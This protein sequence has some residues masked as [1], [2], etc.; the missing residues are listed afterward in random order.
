MKPTSVIFLIVSILLA[1]LGVLLCVTATSLATEQGVGI[2][3]QVGDED[4]NY[5]AT[6]YFSEEELKKIVVKV[7]NVSVNVIGGAEESKIELVN[8][9][10]GAYSVQAGRSTLQISDNAGISGIIDLE[11]FKI[12]FNGFRDYLPYIRNFVLGLPQKEQVLNVYLTDDADLVNFNINVGSGDITVSGLNVDCDYKIVLESGVVHFEDVITTS[13]VQIESI[14]SSNIDIKKVETNELRIVSPESEC[15]I[16]ISETT[17]T[18]AMYV[19]AKSGDIVYDR[20]ENDF[21]GLDVILEALGNTVSVWGDNYPDTYSE[22]NA[23][24]DGEEQPTDPEGDETTAPEDE[25]TA[26]EDTA[27]PADP[28]ETGDDTTS[29]DT[30]EIG[31]IEDDEEENSSVTVKANTI[32]IKIGDGKIEVK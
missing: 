17:F 32:T 31:D 25:T 22:F 16:N 15:F 18:R 8:F 2:F 5:V 24:T 26:P 28:D 6:E 19:E 10:N 27:V 3:A 13:S 4:D 14:Q 30:D 9:A 20:V 7:S 1:C 12:N 23:P 21:A 11:N 29:E